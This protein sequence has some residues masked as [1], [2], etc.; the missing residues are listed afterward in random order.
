MLK[1]HRIAVLF[2]IMLPLLIMTVMAW[3][4][5][6]EPAPLTPLKPLDEFIAE[7]L[8]HGWKI[9]QHPDQSGPYRW[10]GLPHVSGVGG[11]GG[12]RYQNHK[13]IASH[14]FVPQPG[15]EQMAVPLETGEGYLTIVV[16]GRKVSAP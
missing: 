16:L 10:G 3:A 9:I 1:T 14:S 13:N 11:R 12:I 7:E 8:S 5:N 6:R 15:V 2:W 4:G